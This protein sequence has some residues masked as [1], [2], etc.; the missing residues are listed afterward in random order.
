MNECELKNGI[1]FFDSKV[2]KE[3]KCC[4]KQIPVLIL[5]EVFVLEKLHQKIK[6]FFL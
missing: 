3:C 2:K 4:I 1:I 6:H 5:K